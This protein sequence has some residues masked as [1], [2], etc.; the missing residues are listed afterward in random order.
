MKNADAI[1]ADVALDTGM[2]AREAVTRARWWWD[3]RARHLLGKAGADDPA[4]AG[5]S[6]II[7]M[8]AF[9]RL[10]KREQV[11]IVKTWHHFKIRRPDLL[12]FDADAKF[13]LGGGEVVQ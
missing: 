5:V 1:L 10:T 9:D 3:N 7:G 13:K 8:T 2:T 12:G 6:G 11:V 4:L